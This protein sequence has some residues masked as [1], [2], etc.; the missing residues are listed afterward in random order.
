LKIGELSTNFNIDGG[1]A[2]FD[3]KDK[4]SL[5][6]LLSSL[7]GVSN[8]N[9]E[10]FIPNKDTGYTTFTRSISIPTIDFPDICTVWDTV[11]TPNVPA[12]MATSFPISVSGAKY[13]C[14]DFDDAEL[15]GKDGIVI[16]KIEI[17]GYTFD[18]PIQN[19]YG[20]V[21]LEDLIDLSNFGGLFK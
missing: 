20:R 15:I 5:S 21:N 14:R 6:A 17:G 4:L 9:V 2:F 3:L 11:A 8:T 7:A 13:V 10:V 19:G 1:L 18:F 16:G 12:T